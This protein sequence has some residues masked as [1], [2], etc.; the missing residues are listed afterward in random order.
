MPGL[1]DT[2]GVLTIR[3]LIPA[4]MASAAT[5]DETPVAVLPTNATIKA[6]R[7]IP[8]AAVVANVTNFSIL[9]V[10]N[11]GAAAAGAALPLG[12]SWAAVNSTAFVADVMALSGTAADAVANAGDVLTVSRIHSGTGVVIP[13]CIVEIDYVIR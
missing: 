2:P 8:L 1:A 9:S 6:G 7:V 4:A 11:R 5:D 12:R 3:A 13:A 10:R